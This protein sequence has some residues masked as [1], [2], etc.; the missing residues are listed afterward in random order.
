VSIYSP[1]RSGFAA[2]PA[3][4]G[5]PR[6]RV[7][8]LEVLGQ[9]VIRA[10]AP[11]LVDTGCRRVDVLAIEVEGLQQLREQYDKARD[12]TAERFYLDTMEAREPAPA[13]SR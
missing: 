6:F 4:A 1:Y 8:A 9:D 3:P 12:I 5:S 2:S 7:S 10:F 11:P 13:T